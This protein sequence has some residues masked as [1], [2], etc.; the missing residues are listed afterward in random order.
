MTMKKTI[1]F[2]FFSIFL[3]KIERNH[4]QIPVVNGWSQFTPSSDSRLIY[5][6]DIS[7][8]DAT[9]QTYLPSSPA[10]GAD[11]FNPSGNILAYKT[12]AAAKTQLRA[13]Y[14]DWIL[15][16]RGETWVNQRIG[17]VSLNGRSATEPM[18][19]AAYGACG[20][21]PQ[22][23][24]GNL[25]FIHF[26]GA[27][28][29][30]VAIIG[31]HAYPH[32]RS[33]TDDPI[34]LHLVN[35]PFSNFLVEDCFFERFHGHFL[36]QDNNSA[37]AYLATR[38]NFKARRNILVDAY[39]TSAAHAGGMFIRNVNGILFEENLIDHNGWSATIS[40]ATPTQY[41]HNVYFQVS[42]QN[43][44]FTKNIVSR[45]GATGGSFR[46]GGTITDNLFLAN[47]QSIQFGTEEAVDGG[48]GGINFPSEFRTGEVANNV[49]LDARAE[50]FDNGK[51][52]SVLKIKNAN[53]HN[54]IIAHFTPVTN[55]NIGVFMNYDENVTVENNVIYKWGNNLSAGWN[56]ANGIRIGAGLIGTNYL[57][58]NEIQMTNTLGTCITKHGAV[59]NISLSNNKYHSAMSSNNWF[60]PSGSFA[61]WVAAT[62]ETGSQVQAIAYTD[63]NRN[64]G[65]YM[66]S[67]GTSGNLADFINAAKTQS[68]CSWNTDYT[69]NQVNNY[70]R[71][72][73]GK[74]A[75]VLAIDVLDFQAIAQQN[76]AHLNWKI[77][78]NKTLKNIEIQRSGDGV[79]FEKIAK[80][81]AQ[82]RQFLDKNLSKGDYY[83]RL[84]FHENDG[85][86]DY[87][88]IAHIRISDD[89]KSIL[90]YPNPT[91]GIIKM[92]HE[93]DQIGDLKIFIYDA[94]GKKMFI[95]SVDNQIDLSNFNTGIYFIEIHRNGTIINQKTIKI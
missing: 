83:Y 91:T 70:I 12:I 53:I 4:A 32:T 92:Q 38:T 34:A 68:R 59:A 30:N 50:T 18:L 61:N 22:I 47:P 63:P 57:N 89:E 58:N 13:G 40:G 9:A 84:L 5:V 77:A 64:I 85:N 48:G 65:S 42:C 74:S 76:E 71:I 72:G 95:K 6:S 23:Q 90:L 86:M 15:F 37:N 41:R 10:I 24:T 35:A 73:F 2:L 93:I 27:S 51:G 69:A 19:I 46:C 75:I 33:G 16:K 1:I 20:T 54:N 11:P 39:T 36:I 66:T 31:I 44:V 28:A 80:I 26:F 52:I 56:F 17:V 62:G 14:P 3:I 8:N 45:A 78:D 88:S 49:I 87:S 79:S 81:S 7:G 29:S 94:F 25:D 82:S 60:E 43:L 21:R 67:I 55:Y